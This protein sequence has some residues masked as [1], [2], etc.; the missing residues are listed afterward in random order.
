MTTDA[1]D[2]DSKG[3]GIDD[4]ID[5]GR[6]Q[7]ME[8]RVLDP[9]VDPEQRSDFQGL[10]TDGKFLGKYHLIGRDRSNLN[11]LKDVLGKYF[12]IEEVKIL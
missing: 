3:N 9:N 11:F 8:V 2:T 7:M 5:W 6:T 4:F 10:I 1:G 12:K